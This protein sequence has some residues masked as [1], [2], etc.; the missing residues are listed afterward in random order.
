MATHRQKGDF[1][2]AVPTDTMA[3]DGSAEK[4]TWRRD[5]APLEGCHTSVTHTAR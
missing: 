3:A 4:H 5:V 1:F 2:S